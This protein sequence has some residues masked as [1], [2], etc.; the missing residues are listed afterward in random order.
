MKGIT[1]LMIDQYNLQDIDFMGYRFTKSNATFH[2]LLIPRR[3]NGPEAVWNGAILNGKTSHPYLHLVESKDYDMFLAITSE[4]V[5]ENIKGYLD[6]DNIRRIDDILTE[7]EKEYG[8][9]RTK[10]GKV[11]IKE[12][13]IKGRKF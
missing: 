12:E 4:M 13:Y 6:L 8:N 7:F 5:D 2:H 11:L 9:K 10:K 3:S 1:H